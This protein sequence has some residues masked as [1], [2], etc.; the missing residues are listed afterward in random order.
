MK[1]IILL[2]AILLIS[3]SCS[4]DDSNKEKEYA[5]TDIMGSWNYSELIYFDGSKVAY[6]NNT[7]CPLD[8]N[9]VEF[10]PAYIKHHRFAFECNDNV[11]KSTIYPIVYENRIKVD[12]FL[13]E[14]LNNGL[15]ESLTP[16]TLVITFDEPRSSV[17]ININDNVSG[18]ILTK[19]E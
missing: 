13:G 14:F 8:K 1:K 16:T 2:V 4:K 10:I 12:N 9:Y 6:Q 19:R 15:I 3:F 5:Y 17:D 18:I 11:I 7:D